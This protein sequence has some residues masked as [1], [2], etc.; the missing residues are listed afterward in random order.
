MTPPVVLGA[1]NHNSGF[2]IKSN[3]NTNQSALHIGKASR[4]LKVPRSHVNGNASHSLYMG[5]GG[6]KTSSDK[7]GPHIQYQVKAGKPNSMSSH[8]MNSDYSGDLPPM[9]PNTRMLL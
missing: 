8:E 6:N 9:H 4:P 2:K 7:K 3:G 5:G 1:Q